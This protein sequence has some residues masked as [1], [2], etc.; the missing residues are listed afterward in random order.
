[1]IGEGR[2]RNEGED[3]KA[4]SSLCNPRKKKELLEE[5]ERS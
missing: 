4:K 2:R 5:E 3:E 1:M